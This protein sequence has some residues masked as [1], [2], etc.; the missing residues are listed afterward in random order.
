[1][2]NRSSRSPLGNWAVRG[3]YERFDAAGANP[4]L[5]SLGMTYWP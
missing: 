4:A 1:V 2:N 3:E 5:L